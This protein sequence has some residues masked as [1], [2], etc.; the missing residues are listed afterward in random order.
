MVRGR[1]WGCIERDVYA[2]CICVLYLQPILNG[3]KRRTELA[4]YNLITRFHK[5][6]CTETPRP[7]SHG[8][9]ITPAH[10]AGKGRSCCC[11]A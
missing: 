1:M 6:R 8:G 10:P 5:F 4:A 2:R 9:V 7:G 3:Y 11:R